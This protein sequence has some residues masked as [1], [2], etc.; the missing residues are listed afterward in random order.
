LELKLKPTNLDRTV[1]LAYLSVLNRLPSESEK[2]MAVHDLKKH[3]E[4][5]QK[6]RELVVHLIASTGFRND[7]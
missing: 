2:R 7:C 6:I 1:E 5:D 4:P 3:P